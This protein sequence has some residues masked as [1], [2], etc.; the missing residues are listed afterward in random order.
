MPDVGDNRE[1][2]ASND[3]VKLSND[4]TVS[5]FRIYSFR[6]SAQFYPFFVLMFVLFCLLLCLKSG[7]NNDGIM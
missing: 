3:N 2:F 6:L 5:H 1:Y 7:L 4:Y